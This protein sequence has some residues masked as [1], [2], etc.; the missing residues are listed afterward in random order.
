MLLNVTTAGNQQLTI[1]IV[2]TRI[3]INFLLSVKIV[4][5]NKTIAAQMNAGILRIKEKHQTK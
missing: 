3:V 2:T 5:S 1:L 4:K